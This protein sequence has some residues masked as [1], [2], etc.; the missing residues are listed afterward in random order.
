MLDDFDVDALGQRIRSLRISAG[1]TIEALSRRAGVSRSMVA[2]VEGGEK[3]PTVL[4]LHRIA[5]GLGTDMTS[6][7]G[8]ETR[9]DVVLLRQHEQ[10]VARHL[11]GWE[12]RT[13]SPAAPGTTFAFMRTTIPAGVDTGVFPPHAAGTRETAAVEAGSLRLTIDGT[14]WLV[15]AGDSIT[16]RG[17]VLHGF[18]N[19]G[20]IDCVYYL[21]LHL[22]ELPRPSSP[23]QETSRERVPVDDPLWSQAVEAIRDRHWVTA[24]Y[25]QD[26]L[27]IDERRATGLIA[28]LEQ[29]HLIA[30][31]EIPAHLTM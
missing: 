30:P 28:L 21:T 25:L 10:R 1:L 27:V 31:G 22:G 9:A 11:S 3:A 23:D 12:R 8:E 2:A 24:R 29:A 14:P 15:E 17:D 5:S 26:R 18:T 19:P 16:Y 13:L 20:Q 7:L 4:T 6:L